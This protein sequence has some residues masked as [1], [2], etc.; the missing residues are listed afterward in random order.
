MKRR[1][2]GRG[3]LSAIERLP[4]E[5]DQ[6]I[7]WAANELRN[8]ER[9]QKEIY[10]EF[11]GKLE[12]LQFE[13]F[14]ELDI[15]IPSYSAFNR[16]SMKQAIL[17][18]RLEDTR[19]IAATI[20]EK[21]DAEASDD[22]TLIAAEAIKTLVFELL[23]DAGESGL[24]PK[25]ALDLASALRAAAQ[26]QGVSTQRRQKV[27]KDFKKQADDVLNA[28]SGQLDAAQK[29]DGEAVLRK[30]RAEIYGIFD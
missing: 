10:Q 2:S 21:F 7:V 12:A 19:A 9:T 22:L 17:T 15:K 14:G 6:I 16:Y 13:H 11:S 24:N 28:V 5:C 23:T 8:R 30:I 4:A 29:P 26:A 20:A 18:R 1:R 25:A 3:R 27:E